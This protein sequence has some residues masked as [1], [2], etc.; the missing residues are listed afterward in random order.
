MILLSNGKI[1]YSTDAVNW[2][3]VSDSKFGATAINSIC[4]GN[5]KFVAVG[6]NGKMAYCT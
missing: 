2:T 3:L 6:Y 5:G 4:Y 1:A